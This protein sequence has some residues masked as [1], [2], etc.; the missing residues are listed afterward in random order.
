MS[1]RFRARAALFP[2]LAL[3]T[4]PAFAADAGK[5]KVAQIAKFPVVMEGPRASVPV[6][7]NGKP[8]RVWLDSG[9]FFNFMPK[10]KAVEFGL[11]TE[12]LPAN[13]RVNGIG[14]S[15]NPELARVRDFGVLGVTLHNTEFVVGGSDSGNGFLGA[16][17]LGVWDT[18]FDL[19]KGAVNLFKE[20][21]CNGT[22]MAYWGQGM[23]IGEARLLYADRPDDYHI[24]VEVIINGKSLRA[25]LDSGAPTTVV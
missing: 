11:Q 25:L 10:A 12:A 19:A 4:A 1:E 24:Y 16:N 2:L 13:F 5:C 18:E 22:V 20:S 17:F 14:G 3:I 23:A 21:G 7:F 15:Y 6:S 8:T 9:A